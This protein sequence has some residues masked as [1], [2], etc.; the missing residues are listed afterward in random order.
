MIN[1]QKLV[2]L[3]TFLT[4]LILLVGFFQ[5]AKAKPV[6]VIEVNTFDDEL[7]N[8][9]DCSFREA[10]E[11]AN[12]NVV[13][14]GCAAGSSEE[15]DTI[16]LE[17]GTYQLVI[18]GADNNNQ[19]G[20]L[21]IIG[22]VNIL[23]KGMD[24]TIID[25]GEVDRVFH[26]YQTNYDVTI[27]DLTIQNGHVITGT[28]GGSGLMIHSNINL[29]L[30]NCKIRNNHTLNG[31]GGGI[32]NYDGNVTISNCMIVNNSA[33]EGGGIYN[34]G[35]LFIYNSLISGND[36]WD[37]GGGGG[38]KNTESFLGDGVSVLENVTFSQNSSDN[39]SSIF[40][41]TAITI[42]NGTI[43]YNTGVGAAFI[44][45]GNS[46]FKNTIIG[47]HQDSDNCSGI[48]NFIT[49]GNNLEDGDNC[50]FDEILNDLLNTEPILIGD[51]PQNNGGLTY[52]YALDNNSP[53]IDAGTNIGCPATDQRGF[54]RP[55]DGDKNGT[56]IC[57]IG[58]FEL[59]PYHTYYFPLIAK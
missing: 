51:I 15:T 55:I 29:S 24:R 58:A 21:D 33:S 20:D 2:P 57:D 13:V 44:N 7:N 5:L 19:K 35:E 17:T 1:W 28:G 42:T 46:V 27:S 56:A 23:G 49:L 48:G 54:S 34:D 43:V 26:L 10:I 3:C 39:G 11:A 25:G 40:S 38:L 45:H 36:A 30:N 22:A 41:S 53:A 32:D 18:P 47:L 16:I 9:S 4:V 50:Y 52:T 12:K 59:N 31:F 37:I 14:D 8:D 6:S